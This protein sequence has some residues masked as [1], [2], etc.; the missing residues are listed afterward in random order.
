MYIY[1]YVYIYIYRQRERERER[2]ENFVCEREGDLEHL[3]CGRSAEDLGEREPDKHL[4][5]RALS[6]GGVM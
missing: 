6:N 4:T 5:H 1:M 3:D 2:A